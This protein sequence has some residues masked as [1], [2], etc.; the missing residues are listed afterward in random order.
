MNS[1]SRK[2]PPFARVIRVAV[3]AALVGLLFGFE[4]AVISG[5]TD[6]LLGIFHLS[7]FTLGFTVRS[8][9]IGTV[10]GSWVV[11]DIESK[12]SLRSMT[13]QVSMALP[14][15]GIVPIG[16]SHPFNPLSFPMSSP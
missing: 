5:T 12:V 16:L 6:W 2:L 7:D 10:I 13:I 1:L 3:V 11:G 4:T 15:D 14:L 8:A 9:L